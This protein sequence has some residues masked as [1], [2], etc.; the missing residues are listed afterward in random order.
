M[1][2]RKIAAVIA[3][4]G[5][6]LSLSACSKPAA[7]PASKSI[8]VFAASSLTESFTEIGKDLLKDDNIK[9][10]FNFAGS[11][12][13]ATS[14]EQGTPAD[15]AAYASES[16][17]K[18]TQKNGYTDSYK[19][20]AKNTLV[21]C[22]LKSSAKTIT[23]LADFGNAGVSLIVG[24]PSVP[25]GSYFNTVL[26]KSTLTTAQKNAIDA[27][28]KSKELNVKDVLAKVQSGNGDFGVVYTTDITSQVKDQIQEIDVPEFTDAKP[29][30]PIA[31]LKQSKDQASAQKFVDFVLSS[32]GQA[33]LKKYKFIVDSDT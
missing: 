17:M 27:N 32:K 3:A 19:I 29:L 26:S 20:F 33:I 15:V 21:A 23:S 14:I 24:D 11:Q 25:C 7:K 2:L 10:T 18:E 28:I 6:L 1:K 5:T 8:T 4:C 16:Y 31:V 9:V 13:L 30:Y 22:K 12:Q